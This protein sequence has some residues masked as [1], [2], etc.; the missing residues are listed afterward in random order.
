MKMM[1]Q[2]FDNRPPFRVF[3]GVL[4]LMVLISALCHAQSKE[5]TRMRSYF[6]IHPDGDRQ[7]SLLLTAGRGRNMQNVANAPI[8]IEIDLGDSTLYL[9]EL[10]T[11][12]E[13]SADLYIESGYPLPA[14]EEG[15]TTVLA[16]FGGNDTLRSTDTD[17]EIK[18]VFLE[19][20]FDIE[21]SVK[22]LTVEAKE[23]N[24]DGELV[25][26]EEL[27]IV[28]GVERLYSVLALDEVET[29]EDGI[30]TLEFPEDI[31]GDSVGMLNIVATIEEH[32][33]FGTVTKEQSVNWGVPVS[34]EL[35][36]MPRQLFTD[37]A[38]LWMIIAVFI[39]IV[40]AWYHFFLSV[41]KLYNMK[42]AGQDLEENL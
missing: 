31:P 33:Y 29:D 27:D 42:K 36:K 34:Y 16:S 6:Y 22:I 40:G 14:D 11:N 17:L 30:G 10:T 21:D 7:I 28:I 13:G 24:G 41:L 19:M 25:P 35:K 26:V 38:P 12:Q 20:S 37:E 18:D 39:A 15:I 3:A 2:I 1:K 4:F 23:S 9:T 5:R 32:D 8:D